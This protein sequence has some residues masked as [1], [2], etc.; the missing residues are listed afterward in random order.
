MRVYSLNELFRLTRKQLFD[1]HAEIVAELS[2][3]PEP[4]PDRQLAFANLRL[5]R[6]VLAKLAVIPH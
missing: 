1:L 3:L 2:K 5:I 4:S 6:Q